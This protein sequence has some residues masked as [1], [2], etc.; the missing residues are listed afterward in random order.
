MKARII[1]LI[2]AL[3]ALA[4]WAIAEEAADITNECVISG[5]N[6]TELLTDRNMD[7]IWYSRW[8]VTELRIDFP[9]DKPAQGIYMEWASESSVYTLS[10][11]DAQG[12]LLDRVAHN[13]RFPALNAYYPVAQGAAYA[14]IAMPDSIGICDIYVYGQGELPGT[15]Q[16]WNAPYDDAD[17]MLIVAHQDDEELWFGGL[18][19]YYD[20]VLGKNLSVVYM[21]NCSRYR[22]GEALQGL[23]NM[24]IR[25]YPVFLNYQD[26]R[27][28]GG[29]VQ[30][31][32]AWGGEL[33]VIARLNAL[34]QD[35]KPEVI[36]THDIAGEYGH[37]QHRATSWI[38][39]MAALEPGEHR[40]LKFYRHLGEDD[41]IYMDWETPYE[42]LGGLTPIE[43]ATI[44]MEAH[45]S[46]RGTYDMSWGAKDRY[47]NTKFSLIWSLVGPD[48][49]KNDF[50]ENIF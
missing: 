30:A 22:K 45:W 43:V 6:E 19:P 33:S 32:D 13:D 31:V 24:G 34:Y 7:R 2:I 38:T 10:Q 4:G 26:G 47:D 46:Q 8:D 44:G 28:P 16:V 40:V 5:V 29:R 11:Y 15:L 42:E 21:T 35:K 20:V 27:V 17:I 9:A 14:V 1:A 49:N 3:L 41:I 18:I 48:Q 23:W 39:E 50:L 12:A 36:V 37:I 25:N